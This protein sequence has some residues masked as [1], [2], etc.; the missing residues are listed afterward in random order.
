MRPAEYLNLTLRNLEFANI[1]NIEV[2]STQLRLQYIN[3]DNN[4][5]FFVNYPVIFTPSKHKLYIVDDKK[6]KQSEHVEKHFL[7]VLFTKDNK[8]KDINLF[9]DVTLE[10][11]PFSIN[12]EE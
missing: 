11:D 3:I 7:N 12:I 9:K 1:S 5:Q 2:T 6:D 10:L 4:S 8:V